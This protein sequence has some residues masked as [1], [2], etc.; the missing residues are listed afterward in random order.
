MRRLICCRAPGGHRAAAVL[1]VAP[2]LAVAPMVAVVWLSRVAPMVAV[3]EVLVLLLLVL[4]LLLLVLLPS[5]LLMLLLLLLLLLLCRGEGTSGQLVRE[6]V[7]LLRLCGLVGLCSTRRWT[8]WRQSHT[9]LHE[10]G[11]IRR[12]AGG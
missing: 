11:G 3:V 2:F 12:E 9:C 5:K 1:A 4:L 8:G 7:L 10:G 6:Q